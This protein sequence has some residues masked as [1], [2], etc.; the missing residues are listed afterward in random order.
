MG[1][2]WWAR[3]DF[4]WSNIGVDV[5]NRPTEIEALNTLAK[6]AGYLAKVGFDIESL[7]LTTVEKKVFA[8]ELRVSKEDFDVKEFPSVYMKDS[9]VRKTSKISGYSE[10]FVMK[11]LKSVTYKSHVA[12]SFGVN[13]FEP[14]ESEK[15]RAK[16]NQLY[17]WWSNYKKTYVRVV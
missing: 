14:R 15:E 11:I 1:N 6:Q 10:V 3:E 7:R 8:L 2:W 5:V 17:N 12:E 4:D 16:Y 13:I 9:S